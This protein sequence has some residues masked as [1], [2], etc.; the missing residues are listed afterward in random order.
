[1][2]ILG[3][4]QTDIEA[5]P[6]PFGNAKNPTGQSSSWFP[7]FLTS[8]EEQPGQFCVLGVGRLNFPLL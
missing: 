3:D 4:S 5:D 7:S 8:L 2:M 1:M 6:S